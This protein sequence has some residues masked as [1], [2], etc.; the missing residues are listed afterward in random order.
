[1]NLAIVYYF[2]PDIDEIWKVDRVPEAAW[3]D[4]LPSFGTWFSSGSL[5]HITYT[6]IIIALAPP[7]SGVYMHCHVFLRV[8]VYGVSGRKNA[9]L[10][11]CIVGMA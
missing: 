4:C 3:P 7:T 2:H 9:E 11:I 10:H 8:Q 5:Q 1:L 6:A